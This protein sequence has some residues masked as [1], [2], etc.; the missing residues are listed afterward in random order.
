MVQ[1]QDVVESRRKARQGGLEGVA[2]AALAS[3]T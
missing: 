1:K 3:D 2:H